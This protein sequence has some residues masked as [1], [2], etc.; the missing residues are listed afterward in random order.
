[1]SDQ[2]ALIQAW[3]DALN[4][5]DTDA[6]LALSHDDIEVGGPR[7]SGHGSALLRDWVARAG[8]RLQ[9]RRWFAKDDALVVEQLATWRDPTT[10]QP[11][12][13]AGA[14]SA[15]VVDAGRVRRVLRYETLDAALA[16]A[17][18]TLQDET[19]PQPR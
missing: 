17:G 14:A 6:L 9:P 13:P 8:I 12:P 4:R 10:G 5:G 18:L 1:M 7:G 3:H 2:I 11:T 15:F 19:R 16:A